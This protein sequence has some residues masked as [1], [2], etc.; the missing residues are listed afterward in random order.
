MAEQLAERGD[1]AVLVSGG[2]PVA[3]VTGTSSGFGLLTVLTLARRGYRVVAAMRDLERRHELE[4]RAAREG[5]AER[6]RCVRLD[7][8]EHAS[9]GPAV[10]EIVR[11]YGRLDMLV[12]N[13]GM[14]VGG[15]VEEVPMEDWRRQMETNLFGV[16]AVTRAVLPVMR[17]QRRGLVV[18][19]SSVSGLAGFP[20][21]APYAASK[22]AIEGFSESLRHE[23]R[24]FGVRVVLVEPGAY[25][26][27]IWNKGIGEIRIDP[28]SPYRAQLEAVLRYS[29]K[30]AETAPDPQEVADLI[31]RI[32][33]MRAPR[34]RYALGQ[35][36]R[37]LIW[38]KAL[39]PWKWLE[40]I[41]AKALR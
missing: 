28:G 18:N 36:S 7:V 8:T 19:V 35:G 11:R 9:I 16:I 33:G 38:S 32:A 22:F 2:L 12:N 5:T 37:L 24:P 20:G 39:L 17:A 30:A 23:I 1:G 29:R 34:L 6:I 3:L 41:F 21:Y 15:F 14:A 40:W 4:Q 26:T 27:P 10:D 25:R 31:G 13:A